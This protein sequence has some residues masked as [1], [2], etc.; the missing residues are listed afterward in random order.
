M[1]DETPINGVELA[2]QKA[3]GALQLAK[4]LQVTH[5]AIYGWLK[6]G[7]V[8]TRH[9]VLIEQKYGI[10]RARTLDPHILDIIALSA[11]DYLAKYEKGGAD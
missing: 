10:N 5:Q 3:G 2:A 6:R 7:W 4:V 11:D 9:A 8:P 1:T